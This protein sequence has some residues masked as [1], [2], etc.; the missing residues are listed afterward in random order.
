ML[1]FI[2]GKQEE[3]KK[4]WDLPEYMD[5]GEGVF[6]IPAYRRLKILDTILER[7]LFGPMLARFIKSHPDLEILE[8]VPVGQHDW[9]EWVYLRTR[10]KS[11]PPVNAEKV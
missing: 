1:E 6:A 11:A 4:C 8:M 3:P 2:F 9:N 7:E 10:P 5:Y